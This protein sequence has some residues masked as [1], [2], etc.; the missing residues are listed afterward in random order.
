MQEIDDGAFDKSF[1]QRSVSK[2]KANRILQISS[3]L[4]SLLVV[5]IPVYSIYSKYNSSDDEYQRD[6]MYVLDGE[7][8]SIS[9]TS[10]SDLQL[11]DDEVFTLTL[12]NEDFPENAKNR[13]IV[14][15]YMTMQVFDYQDDNEET[16][17]VGCA[18]DSGE[19]AYDSVSGI[20][21]TPNTEQPL[22]YE[23]DSSQWIYTEF[24]DE[25]PEEMTGGLGS[26]Y[27]ITGYTIKEIEEIFH[28]GDKIIGQYN[29]EFTGHVESGESTFQCE[30]QDPNVT[31]GYSIELE[32]FEVD[33]I[34]FDDYIEDMF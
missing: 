13:N 32:W 30:R 31:I 15:L 16:S 3:I 7:S 1:F 9:W 6:L 20:V 26:P 14:A 5:S 23:T 33:V 29:F 19:D 12:T 8:G 21:S 10:Q 4:V 2:Y 24:F 27:A 34:E 25:F 11:N 28:T 17:G 22:D 18:I